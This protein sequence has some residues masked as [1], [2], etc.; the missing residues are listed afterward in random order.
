MCGDLG[1]N[2]VTG[3]TAASVATAARRAA[4]EREARQ[5]RQRAAVPVLDRPPKHEAK[6]AIRTTALWSAVG[7]R[8]LPES[9]RSAQGSPSPRREPATPAATLAT[10]PRPALRRVRNHQATASGAP[11]DNGVIGVRAA[12]PAAAARRAAAER[13]ARQRRQRAA[14]PVLDRP[15]KHEAKPAIR[16]TALWSAVGTRGLPESARSAQGSP[17]PRREPATPAATLATA[18]RP[19]LRRVRNHQATASG[20]P[21]DNGVI[22]VRAAR[23]AAAARRAGAER[24]ERP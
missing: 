5:R 1:R 16:T 6:P 4:A 8:G 17:S 9:A 12:R 18:P 23:P 19:A 15:P 22:G 11:G 7:T 2:G 21:G 10:A 13:E 24:G 3:P 20:A 14:V